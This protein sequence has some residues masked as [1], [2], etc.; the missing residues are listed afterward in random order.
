MGGV[1]QVEVSMG[2]VLVAEVSMS[3]VAV[4]LRTVHG[5][6]KTIRTP[7]D[8]IVVAEGWPICLISIIALELPLFSAYFPRGYH[9]HFKLATD[10]RFER[11]HAP[12]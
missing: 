8:I 6:F 1:R 7:R 10:S 12:G 3:K 5:R 4:D 9:Q 11:W 2:E